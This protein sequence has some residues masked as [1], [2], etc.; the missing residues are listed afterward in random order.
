MNLLDAIILVA[1]AGAAIGGYRL[2]FL[3]R[4]TS[5]IGLGIGLYVAARSLPSVVGLLSDDAGSTTRLLLAAVIL[6]GGAF[7]GQALGI[8]AGSKLR[9]VLPLGPLRTA[10][11]IVGAFVGALGVIISVW[12][13]LPAMSEVRGD[14]A[15]LAR[16]SRMA[17]FIDAALPQPPPAMRSLRGL[18]ENSG[19]PKV[20]EGLTR[21]PAAGPPPASSGLPADVLARVSASTVKIEGRA[22]SRIQDGSGFVTSTDT[23]VTNAHVVAG[24]GSPIY[25][26]RP[27]GKKVK[28]FVSV[29]DTDRD[30]AVLKAPGG[31]LGL[32][33]LPIVTK[34]VSEG[35][36]GAVL[37]H[38][39]G[40]DPLEVA[41]SQVSRRVDAIGR[42]LYDRHPIR[43]DVFIMASSLA[44]G[45]SGGPFVTVNG[46]VAGVAFA[47]A[48]DR[49][50]VAY[51][52]T[53]VELRKALVQDRGA[54]VQTG[55]CLSG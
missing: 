14:V 22:C 9:T 16:T 13:L 2:G 44:P 1:L 42:D 30:I 15:R 38:P 19:F 33:A 28:M 34:T 31:D 50:N 55:K 51:A 41:P 11:H 35:V 40:Q 10:D 5:W 53:D 46:E 18:V 52:L 37:G 3:A 17:G 47:I 7:V 32:K 24:D 39:G 21:A 8:V 27:D 54:E 45:Y 43:R 25:A 20:F 49:E 23:V 36:T 6:V 48:P 4:V 12:F 26:I 29:M